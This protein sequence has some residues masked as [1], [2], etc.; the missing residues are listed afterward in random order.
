M[1]GY[2][3]QVGSADADAP[4]PHDDLAGADL[5]LRPVIDDAQQPRGSLQDD[6]SQCALFPGLQK[7]RG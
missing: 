3:R 5:R 4:D 2:Q 1:T 6:C 7:Y